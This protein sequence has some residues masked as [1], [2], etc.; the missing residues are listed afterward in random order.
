MKNRSKINPGSALTVWLG[1]YGILAIIG[2][3]LNQWNFWWIF[4]K[5][6]AWPL[7][8]VC[9]IIFGSIQIPLT[10]VGWILS[11]LGVHLPLFNN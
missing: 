11:A 8:L 3:F 5:D 7:D 6:L 9:G 4:G 1:C 10:V 2:S